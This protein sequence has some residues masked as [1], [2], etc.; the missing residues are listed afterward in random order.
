MNK[1]YYNIKKSL[2]TYSKD[3]IID[4]VFNLLNDKDRVVGEREDFLVN[5]I[6]QDEEI[7]RLKKEIKRLKKAN[8]RCVKAHIREVQ[9]DRNTKLKRNKK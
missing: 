2:Y 9:N 8:N 1:D 7:K 6:E 3:E 5:V 4:I